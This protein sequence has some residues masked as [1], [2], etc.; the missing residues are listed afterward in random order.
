LRA[1]ALAARGLDLVLVTSGERFRARVALLH[2][3]LRR[4]RVAFTHVARAARA[5]PHALARTLRRADDAHADLGALADACA[6]TLEALAVS[7]QSRTP[8][9]PRA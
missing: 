5:R 9:A 2:R 6:H 8:P 7:R 4:V 1:Y 3:A